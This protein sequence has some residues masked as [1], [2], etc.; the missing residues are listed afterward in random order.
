MLV[1]ENPNENPEKDQLN[2]SS[3]EL[4][5]SETVEQEI[6]QEDFSGF[7][8]NEII[9]KLEEIV[10]G[11]DLESY[12]QQVNQ[13][14]DLYRQLTREEMEKQKAEFEPED[15]DD[16]FEYN[17]P[18]GEKFESLLKD[19]NQKRI[20]LK[21]KKEK[22]LNENLKQ[23]K[24]I[25]EALRTLPENTTNISVGFEKLQSLQSLWRSIGP[26]PPGMGD[27]LYK[28]YQFY[29]SKFY[30]GVK[31]SNELKDLDRKK[32]LELKTE[33]CE[34]A[35]KL[36]DEPSVKK[37]MEQLSQLQEEWRQIGQTGKDTNDA[38]WERFKAAA[39][40]VYEKKRKLQE[41]LVKK[42]EENLEKKAA[43]VEKL[44]P[45]VAQEHDNHK[46]WQHAV[47]QVEAIFEE[48]KKIGPVPAS[49]N[50]EVWKTFRGLRNE[51]MEK[52]DKFYAVRKDEE[53]ENLKKKV[54]LCEQAEALKDSTDWKKA[55]DKLKHLQAEWKEIGA[56]PRKDSDKIWK[57]FR[58]ACDHFFN[59]KSQNYEEQK[60]KISE[61][62][63]ER[64]DF[65][66][67][68]QA[69]EPSEDQN[70][71]AELLKGWKE[72]WEGFGELSREDRGK[73]SSMYKRALDSF[74]D[75]VKEKGGDPKAFERMKYN[76]L[77][78]TEEGQ[79]QVRRERSAIQAKIKKIEGEVI[80]IENNMAFFGK[81]KN[82]ETMLADFKKKIDDGRAE[83]QR[84]KEQLK[85]LP[86]I[87]EPQR[88]VFQDKKK[89]FQRRR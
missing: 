79:E 23:K 80:A 89:G 64:E 3:D 87:E 18:L 54:A 26:V 38:I 17:D 60:S 15:A 42:Q 83:I 30:E 19:Y 33:L 22:Q 45:V 13:L 65:I 77:M 84:L 7:S 50:D 72:K 69:A 27:E 14:R 11:Q 41:D 86:R 62:L 55:T 74:M 10:S 70:Q 66:A 56:V 53:K 39:D 44:R 32:N 71:N 6:P 37:A 59:R 34:K 68:I 43:L 36:A 76:Q 28:S 20:D 85:V 73:Y 25:L 2:E 9:A 49:N 1:N 75:K 52:K 5:Q 46:D 48:W 61:A 31:L 78:Q 51:F 12:K 24:E 58:A 88:E 81:S 67:S 21:K 29:V 47:E 4:N 35:E 63:K 57:R 40:K 82:A 16:E 8:K